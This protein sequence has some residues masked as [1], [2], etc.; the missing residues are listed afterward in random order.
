M[1]VKIS[2]VK[3]LYYTRDHEWIDFKGTVAYTGIC[4]FK[5]L[6]FKEIHELVFFT[7]PVI[8]K[9]GD[10]IATIKYKDYQVMAHV[11][12]DGKLV[13]V[14]EAL[15]SGNR[16]LLLQQPENNGW[17][18]M[19]VPSRPYE[20]KGLLLSRQYRMIGKKSLPE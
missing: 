12:V 16:N 1:S 11:P 9:P 7:T 19:I 10:I 6:G 20:R 13:S 14:N 8:K 15:V 4:S 5:L 3:D 18:A 2:A 17:I